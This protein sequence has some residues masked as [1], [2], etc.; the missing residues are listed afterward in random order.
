MNGCE[1]CDLCQTR[2]QVVFGTGK[3]Y[4]PQVMIVGEAPGA[5][6]DEKGEPFV[7]KAGEKLN[8]LLA[9]AGLNRDD[10]YITNAVLCRPPGNRNPNSD[11]LDACHWRLKLQIE[12]IKPKLIVLLGKIALTQFRGKPFKGALSKFFGIWQEYK[13][14]NQ[15]SAQVMTSYHP[16]FHLRSPERA[17][18]MTA[19]H[20]KK[21]G[22]WLKKD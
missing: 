19:P 10:V 15:H 20:W 5:D 22:K 21:I 11:E 1:S 2:Q 14:D 6:E 3:Y 16:S 7:G 12:I 8:E 17:K 4:K 9:S 13:I 18:K